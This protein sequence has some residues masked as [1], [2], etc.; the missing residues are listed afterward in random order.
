MNALA[1]AKARA[2]RRAREAGAVMFIVAM[3]I[4]VLASVG[5][6]ALA[7]ASNEVA[8]SGNERQNTQTHYLAGD[9]VV[10]TS[11]LLAGIQGSSI[12]NLMNLS[13]ST[14]CPSLA[15]LPPTAPTKYR[16]CRLFSGAADLAK[17]ISTPAPSFV[18][19]YSGT[20]PYAAGFAPGSLGP[21]PMNGDFSVELTEPANTSPVGFSAGSNLCMAMITATS[22]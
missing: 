4:S 21:T 17:L 16:A 15:S 14:W 19:A 11:R 18:D 13:P 3:T 10:A 20:T 12:Y 6:Y 7:A 8:M 1:G 9:A 22:M 5:I 2:S